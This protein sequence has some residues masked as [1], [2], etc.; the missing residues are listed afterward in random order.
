MALKGVKKKALKQQ[1]YPEKNTNT[2]KRNYKQVKP[3]TINFL[4]SGAGKGGPL[5]A[6][7][8]LGNVQK[9]RKKKVNQ[10][11]KK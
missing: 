10:S 8:F 4:S 7:K 2:V 9:H 3:E 5:S 1:L 6:N 11:K